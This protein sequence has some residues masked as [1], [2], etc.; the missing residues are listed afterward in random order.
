MNGVNGYVVH[1]R[2]DYASARIFLPCVGSGRGTFLSSAGSGGTYWSSVTDSDN[3]YSNNSWSLFFYS[4]RR[5]TI[6]SDRDVLFPVRPVQ[7]FIK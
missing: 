6:N 3:N 5:S 7:E 4:G 2:G 1:G